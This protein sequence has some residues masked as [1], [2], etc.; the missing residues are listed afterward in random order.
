MTHFNKS[1]LDFLND[2]AANNNKPWFEEN[3]GRYDAAREEL[4]AFS[5]EVLP[6]LMTFD[7]SLRDPDMKGYLF[8]IYRDARFAK[9]R[10]Y[11]NNFGLLFVKGGRSALHERAGY[12]LHIEPGNSFVAGG[13]WRP[14]NQ[15][16]NLIREDIAENSKE[17]RRILNDPTFKKE[18]E[19]WGDQLKTAPRGYE[20]DH[21]AVDLLRYKSMMAMHPLKDSELL[22]KD[23]ASRFIELCKALYNFDDYLNRF[24]GK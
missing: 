11:K 10:P 5:A 12:Y 22:K 18:F 13:A 20:K 2:I 1:T 16:L 8:R 19:I 24:S 9:G 7:E 21:P 4:K 6:G 23:F 15:W 14:V 17:L 3:R